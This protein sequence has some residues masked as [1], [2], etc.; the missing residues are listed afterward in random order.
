MGEDLL[1]YAIVDSV[2]FKLHVSSRRRRNRSKAS[3]NRDKLLFGSWTPRAVSNR[4]FGQS[5]PHISCQNISIMADANTC[6]LTPSHPPKAAALKSFKHLLPEIKH[7]LIHTRHD[8][9]KHE[10]E[11]FSAVSSLSD[12]ELAS[13]DESDLVAVRA[14][15]VAYGVIIFGKVKIPAAKGKYVFVRWFA[16]GDDENGDG[17]V[18]AD[19]GEVEYKF[20]S[21][22]TEE[23]PGGDADGTTRYRAIMREKDELFFFNE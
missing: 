19:E 13:F 17:K 18:E 20:H 2:K 6:E 16:G 22:Y 5:H 23:K 15:R 21:F 7:Q 4:T 10:P 8:H 3:T 12:A 9:D 1:D 11:Y 14:G